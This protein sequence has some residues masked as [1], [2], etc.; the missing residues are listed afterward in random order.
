M[1]TNKTI[2]IKPSKRGSLRKAMGAKKDSNLSVDSMKTKLHKKGTTPAMKKKLVFALNARKWKKENGGLVEYGLG[3]WIKD[4]IQGVFGGLKTLA[5]GVLT[6]TGVGAGIGTS[7]IGSGISDIQGEITGDIA[8]K[9]QNLLQQKQLQEQSNINQQL[10]N[11]FNN[12]YLPTFPRG[13]RIPGRDTS[14]IDA[15]KFPGYRKTNM[16]NVP[17]YNFY[18]EPSAIPEVTVTGKKPLRLNSLPKYTP[19]GAGN[20]SYYPSQDM[21]GNSRGAE[22][23]SPEDFERKHPNVMVQSNYRNMYP[24]GG[25]IP[26]G[27]DNAELEKEEVTLG[28]DGSM[29][30]FDLPTHGQATSENQMS[31][32]PGTRVYSDRLKSKEGKTFAELADKIRKDIMKYEKILYS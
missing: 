10:G 11:Q 2:H 24:M 28:N 25:L 13:G 9:K 21:W 19:S 12:E 32:E 23:M 4:N 7:L 16:V 26:Y 3:G 5:G 18:D 1:A 31:L 27:Q 8:T 30:K 14:A 22:T 29:A 20:W 6:A 15:V 17:K